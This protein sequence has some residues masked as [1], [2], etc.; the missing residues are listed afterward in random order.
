MGEEGSLQRHSSSDEDEEL[1]LLRLKDRLELG[2][3]LHEC[4]LSL[5]CAIGGGAKQTWFFKTNLT[6][7]YV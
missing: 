6:D 5:I 4:S 1:L 2:D 3:R 7:I